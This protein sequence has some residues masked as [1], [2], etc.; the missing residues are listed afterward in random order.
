MHV[1]V[2]DLDDLEEN[3]KTSKILGFEGMLVLNP[4]EIP[5]VHKYYSP[6]ELEVENAKEMLV[7]AEKAKETGEGVAIMNKKFIG[8]PMISAA[9][10]V[11]LKNKLI[12]DS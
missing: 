1:S 12:K 4:K 5:L 3:L 2:H 8:P 6:S 10:K 11:L 9:K 7:L